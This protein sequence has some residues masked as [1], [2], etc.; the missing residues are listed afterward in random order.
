M[1]VP[2]F[3]PHLSPPLLQKARLLP[4]KL[5]SGLFAGALMG[6][7]LGLTGCQGRS[8]GGTMEDWLYSA[9]GGEIAKLRP[10]APGYNRKY[11]NI[12]LEPKTKLDFPSPQARVALTEKLESERN[13]AQ[14]LSAAS[15]PLPRIGHPNPPPPINTDSSLT[16]M[17]DDRPPAPPPAQKVAVPAQPT[18][19]LAQPT[20]KPGQAV[21]GGAVSPRGAAPLQYAPTDRSLPKTMPAIIAP[22]PPPIGFPGFAIPESRPD[23]RP[24]IS[25]ANPPGTLVR[26]L[27]SSD[28]PKEGQ[29]KTFA[30]ILS[31]RQGRA[32]VLTGFGVSMGPEAGLQPAEQ[33]AEI[34]LGL[35]RA[36]AVA[37]VLMQNGVPA[38]EIL[39][40]ASAIGDGVRARYEAPLVPPEPETH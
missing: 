14:R 15:G 18:S 7:V 32:V 27:P 38:N 19:V 39:L 16:I 22:P 29:E 1:R 37:G 10:P 35:L 31:D 5:H 36:Q 12:N 8:V 4:A 2:P 25:S 30:R 24:D 34:R 28:Q 20:F 9:E 23:I 33:Q 17:G 13:Y 40:A 3:R 26:F 6:L 21:D 11:P